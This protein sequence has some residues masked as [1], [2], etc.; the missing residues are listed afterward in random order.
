MTN[1]TKS[2][3]KSYKKEMPILWWTRRTSHIIFVMRELTSLGVAYFAIILLLLIG[4]I[5]QGEESYYEFIKLMKSPILIW[6]SIISLLGL[7]FHSVT[8]FNLAPNAMVVKF[9]KYRIPGIVIMLSNYAGWIVISIIV[10][11][12]LLY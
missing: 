12:F 7:I 2:S 11:R 5:S 9:G 3:G 8:W 6:L 10:G 4:A 1:T